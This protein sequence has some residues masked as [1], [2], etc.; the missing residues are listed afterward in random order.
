MLN[1]LKTLLMGANARAEERLTDH[2]AIDLIEQKIRE[3]DQ[4]LA[5]AK[6]ALAGLI[7]RQRHEE[8][9]LSLLDTRLADLE[10]RARLALADGR[11]DLAAT[12]ATAIADLENERAV[13]RQTIAQ[14]ADRVA[15]TNEAVD[16]ANRRI[17]DL[18]QSMISA[19][20]VDA[21][22]KTQKRL[23]RSLGSTAAVREAEEMILRIMQQ[24]E[25]RDEAAVL[26]EIDARLDGS[27]ARDRLA[28]A[29]YGQRLR[30]SADD[31]LARLR[32]T[33]AT[34]PNAA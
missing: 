1:V 24:D 9:T 22:R 27:A 28:E 29:G 5:A 21:E 33:S 32:A 11:E 3:A 16:K 31:V 30:V 34:E 20:A 7:V 15:R 2:F 10:G 17:I 4:G 26:D 25:P 14:L 13:R 23:N 18:K 8:R 6:S 19:R 12:A